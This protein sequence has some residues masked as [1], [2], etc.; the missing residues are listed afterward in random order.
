MFQPNFQQDNNSFISLVR[1][2]NDLLPRR[3]DP[4]KVYTYVTAQ[5]YGLAPSKQNAY[6]LATKSKSFIAGSTLDHTLDSRKYVAN[7]EI[8]RNTPARPTFGTP[9]VIPT[10]SIYDRPYNTNNSTNGSES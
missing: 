1:L 4:S 3:V 9:L 6:E 2:L 5:H 8:K 7:L 10:H